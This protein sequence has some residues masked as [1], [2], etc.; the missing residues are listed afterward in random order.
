LPTLIEHIAARLAYAHARRVYR[1]FIHALEEPRPVQR[2]ILQQLRDLIGQSDFGRRFGLRA[3]RTPGDLKR[4]V[5]LM[6]YE[7]LRPYVERVWAG[8]AG[9]LFSPGQ[10]LVMFATS[11][12]TTAKPKLVPVTPQFVRDYRRGWNTFGLKLLSD[13]RRAILRA[14]L[15]SSSRHD[16]SYS[17]AGV[18]AGAITGLLARTQKGIVRRFYVGR[19]EIARLSDHRARYYLLM[20]LGIVR[21]VAFAITANPATLIQMARTADEESETLLRDVHDGTIDAKFVPCETL[22]ATLTAGLRPAPQRA[23][24]LRHLRATTGTLRPRDYW[25]L[26][27]L[28]CW[29]GG[30]MGHYLQRLREWFGDLPV[31]DIG[32]LA[33]EGRVTIPLEDNTPVGVLDLQSAI[34]EFIPAEQAEAPD[35]ETLTPQE[36]EAGREYAVVLSNSTGLLRYRLGDIVRAHGHLGQAPLLEFLCRA[37]RVASVAGEKLTEHQAVAA[38]RQACRQLRIADFDFIL[39][40]CWGDPPH[41]RLTCEGVSPPTLG[42]VVDS[43]L[44]AENDEYASRRKSQRLGM[45]T[46]RAVGAGSIAAMDSRLSAQRGSTSEQYKRPCL[47]TA[48]GDDDRA[49]RPSTR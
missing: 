38:V 42:E 23:A 39:A 4:A 47:F 27:F 25:S 7:E 34:F 5:P 17:P 18:P 41:Y 46:V 45:L 16:A 21:D 6:S 15:Q 9:A 31:R 32:L 10:T 44:A 48:P 11:S 29:T 36:L 33:S 12:G 26:T 40:P 30:S 20:R 37:G 19:P 49:L 13:H 24:Q 22:R 14:I 1:R 3:V 43:A 2:R 28:A 35:P 8:D